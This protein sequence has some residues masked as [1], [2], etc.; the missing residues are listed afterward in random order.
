M[1]PRP[2]AVLAV[3]LVEV[4]L[5]RGG[6]E[7]GAAG[8]C[9]V[10]AQEL[11]HPSS[12]PA[13]ISTWDQA[14]HDL[15]QRRARGASWTS[16][17]SGRVSR[18][19]GYKWPARPPPRQR[20]GEQHE[21]AGALGVQQ[22]DLERDPPAEAVPDQMDTVGFERIE[23]IDHGPE[24]RTRRRI[25][26]PIGL[27]ESPKPGRSTAMTREAPAQ[28]RRPSAGKRA[29]CGAQ[30][31]E[32]EHRRPA[33]RFHHRQSGAA[34]HDDPKPQPAFGSVSPV[35]A[36]RNP[37]PTCKLRRTDKRPTWNSRTPPR[38]SAAIAPHVRSSAVSVASGSPPGRTSD[39]PAALE[40]H[41]SH[42]ASNDRQAHT[43]TPVGR[44]ESRAVIPTDKRPKRTRGPR[45][46]R[47]ERFRHHVNNVEHGRPTSLIPRTHT[48]PTARGHRPDK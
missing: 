32:S 24:R 23:Q 21:P 39:A 38:T 10:G 8:G 2:E 19:A 11:I 25:A 44:R 18:K 40:Q 43:R 14:V 3:R 17:S 34:S 7:R 30:P 36:A 6:V 42:A 5:A 35:V 12:G 9:Q 31:M 22:P 15:L 4:D 47:C 20:G 27:S 1:Q 41:V 48:G 29:F 26:A 33:S 28:P 37:T 13:L 45:H 46:T 16:P